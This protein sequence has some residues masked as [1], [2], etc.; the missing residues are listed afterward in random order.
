MKWIVLLAMVFLV[1]V[2]AG[3]AGGG[4]RMKEIELTETQQ[5]FRTKTTFKDGDRL[6][7]G[8]SSRLPG[9]GMVG[10]LPNR[11]FTAEHG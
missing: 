3:C 4:P 11:E 7:R 5:R 9:G 6:G 1:A 10:P 8:R 2:A